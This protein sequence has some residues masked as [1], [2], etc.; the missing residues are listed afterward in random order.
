MHYIKHTSYSTKLSSSEDKKKISLRI[1]GGACYQLFSGTQRDPTCR[2]LLIGLEW[3]SLKNWPLGGARI[4]KREGA[5]H[6]TAT[7]KNSWFRSSLLQTG[8]LADQR[9]SYSNHLSLHTLSH[10]FLYG[11]HIYAMLCHEWAAVTARRRAASSTTAAAPR[12]LQ[13]Y[14][15]LWYWSAAASSSSAAKLKVDHST[16]SANVTDHWS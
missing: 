6:L 8:Q 16:A 12:P 15:S 13:C 5:S 2:T 9:T 4:Y 1:R 3:K 10:K 14:S 11:S 7:V